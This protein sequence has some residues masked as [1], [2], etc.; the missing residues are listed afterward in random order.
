MKKYICPA[1]KL[2]ALSLVL[3]SGVYTMIVLGIAKVM[4][5]GGRGTQI[6]Q[7]GKSYYANIGQS[8]TEDRFFQ[9]RP[10]AVG[11]NAAGSGGSSK[12]TTNPE[13]LQTVQAR[14]EIGRE[15]V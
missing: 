5:D 7:N 4:P 12:G 10:S 3:L 2:T 1:I 11:Y 8:F 15:H 13:Y 6:T 9:G 14:I